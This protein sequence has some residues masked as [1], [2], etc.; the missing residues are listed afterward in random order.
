[1]DFP[2]TSGKQERAIKVTIYGPEGIGKSTLASQFPDALVIDTEGGG[3][4][5]LDVRRLPTPTSWKM[6]EQE[7]DYVI[8]NPGLCKTLVF[9][10]AD[11]AQK[12]CFLAVCEDNGTDGIERIGYGKGYVYASEKFG[13][14][15]GKC[16]KLISKGV[17]VVFVAHAI[18]RKVELPE[19]S[20]AYDHWELKLQQKHIAPLLKEWSD[21]LLFATYKTIVVD[22]KTDMAGN[23]KGKAKGQERVIY[24]THNAAWD[25]KNRYGLP[26]KIPM[27]F[28]ALAP[29]FGNTPKA[30]QTVT[31]PAEPPKPAKADNP[32]PKPAK[33][34]KKPQSAADEPLP[35]GFKAVTGSVA[36]EVAEA[37]PDSVEKDPYAGVDERLADLMK[38]AKLLPWDVEQV[39]QSR[40][41]AA[42]GQ[43]LK[44]YPAALVNWVI[45]F[46]DKVKPMAQDA[47]K[48]ESLPL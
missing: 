29:M 20:G 40:G 15:L 8:Q 10:T 1:M 9:D 44:D 41:K 5:Q 17:N 43:K 47:K 38:A 22:T 33:P 13:K 18:Q 4:S 31:K 7:V 48:Q 42:F 6:L 14:L 32:A 25:A 34:D 39:C 3:T 24:T 28:E 27:K 19:E 37:F 21:A 46:W 11:W 36:K 12:L 23:V 16:D 45:K 26:A 2:I 30:A 35:E